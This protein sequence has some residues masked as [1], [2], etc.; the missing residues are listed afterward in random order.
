MRRLRVA[1]VQTDAGRDIGRNLEKME[2]MASAV[3]GADIIALPEV[4]AVRGSHEDYRGAAQPVDGPIS[5]RVAD[6]A[7]RK[8]AWVIAGSIIEKAGSKTYNTCVL[9][10]R[11]GGVEAFYRKIHLFEARLEDGRRIRE[12]D[13]YS[14]GKKPVLADVEGWRIGLAICYDLRFPELF[15]HYSERGA[16]LVFVPSNFTQ[17]TG[18]DHWDVLVKARAIENQCFVVAPNQCGVNRATGV[19]SHGHSIAVGPWGEV[20]CE[21]GDRERVL[22]TVLDPSLLSAARSRVP[23]LKHRVM[24]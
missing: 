13:D 16:H 15:R 12:S 14:P 1:V 4:F 22:V 10:N 11:D 7:R 20:L 17:R 3:R 2:D 9:F 8:R 6:L 23:A 18:R 24:R 19:K 5:A 21:A